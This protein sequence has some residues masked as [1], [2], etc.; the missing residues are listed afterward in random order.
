MA[1]GPA[2]HRPHDEAPTGARG[3]GEPGAAEDLA[4]GRITGGAREVV[5]GAVAIH[6]SDAVDVEAR[7]FIGAI[8]H[9]V[10]TIRGTPGRSAAR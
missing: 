2:R 10:R 8:P 6:A 7:L 4:G 9:D 5:P 1:G 3:R